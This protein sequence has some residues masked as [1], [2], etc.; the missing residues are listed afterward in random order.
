MI[1]G[2]EPIFKPSKISL[3]SATQ[4]FYIQRF[5]KGGGKHCFVGKRRIRGL[6]S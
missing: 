3:L 1:K 4:N 6:G 2:H 5:A